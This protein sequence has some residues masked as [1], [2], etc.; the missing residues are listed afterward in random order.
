MLIQNAR[1]FDGERLTDI[2]AVRLRNGIVEAVDPALSP[3]PGERV[4]D[5]AGDWLVPGFVDVHIHAFRGH[6]TMQGEEAV[7]QMSRDLRQLGVAAFCPT[8]MSASPEETHAALGGIQRVMEHPEP[9]GSRVIGAHMEAPFLQ[10][11]KAGAQRC[12]FFRDPDWSLLLDW[13]DGHP[14]CVR[15]ITV[16]PERAG[17]EAFIR[18]AAAAGIHVS[19]GHTDADA[20]AAHRAADWGADH[21]THT[22]NA[23]PPLHH[24]KPGTVGAALTDDRLWCEGIFDGI[25]LDWD[26]VR[27]L[28]RCKGAARAVAITDAMEAAGMPDGLYHLG[29]Q[30]V[31]VQEG[32]ARL[33]DGTLA[34]SVLTLG[35]AL[36]NL[37][38]KAGIDPET[39][40][41]LCTSTPADSVGE[42]LLGRIKPG[43]PAVMT[44]WSPDWHLIETVTDD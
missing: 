13:T 28:V 29:G 2:T 25:H 26:I 14:E 9:L 1:L 42:P 11:K 8:T 15:L 31:R 20:A 3:L 40:C 39:A 43:A 17:S 33:A 16:A 6:D 30:E 36:E 24:R 4:L 5:L 32:A 22:F 19:I 34:G 27:L 12:E 21:V 38:H 37:I 23:Q 41:A 44:R 7:R 18:Q 10:E 35:R